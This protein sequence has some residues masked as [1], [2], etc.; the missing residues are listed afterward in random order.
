MR[1]S[2]SAQQLP[3][4]SAA[5]ALVAMT[6]AAAAMAKRLVVFFS[7]PI[8]SISTRCSVSQKAARAARR[9]LTRLVRGARTRVCARHSDWTRYSG[10]A[11]E[12]DAELVVRLT[13]PPGLLSAERPGCHRMPGPLWWTLEEAPPHDTQ[14]SGR[15]GCMSLTNTRYGCSHACFSAVAG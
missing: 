2:R 7:P 1:S 8:I 4:R 3:P 9:Q 12:L 11:T 14:H 6:L 13:S 10:D 15:P 5:M